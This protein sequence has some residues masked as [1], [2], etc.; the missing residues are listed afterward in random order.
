MFELTA[1]F[2]QLCEGLVSVLA[3]GVQNVFL[4]RLTAVHVC[5]AGRLCLLNRA[6][7]RLSGYVRQHKKGKA[8]LL[9]P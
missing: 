5:K 2:A 4:D 8:C 9:D 6:G 1:Q 3:H 7:S